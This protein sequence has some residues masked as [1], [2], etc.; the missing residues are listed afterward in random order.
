MKGGLWTHPWFLI[1]VLLFLN[2]GLAVL[3]YLPYGAEIL[4]L[5]P[6]R[7]EPLNSFFRFCT[8]LGEVPAFV[9]AGFAALFWK[10]RFAL[11]VALAGAIISPV[12]YLL[13]DNF[14]ADRPITY[15][16]K[17]GLREEVALVPDVDLNGGQTSFPSGHTMAAFGLY[18][19]L[20]LMLRPLAPWLGL[21]CAWTAMLVG[22]SRIFLVQH[23]LSDVM[24]GATAGVF[25]AALV[26]EIDRR[27]L[28][29]W[30]I[31]DKGLLPAR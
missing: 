14:G 25:V 10:Y 22:F 26:W 23:F 2:A 27:F 1:P 31:L 19:L 5:N 21:A 7:A 15:F 24:G 4:L 16:E 20:A 12:S 11:L 9:F 6:F 13:K 3:L 17:L 30:P 28:R 29:K 8:H 18:A